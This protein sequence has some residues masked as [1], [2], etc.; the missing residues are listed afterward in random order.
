M[1]KLIDFFQDHEKDLKDINPIYLTLSLERT[2]R[3][4]I[5]CKSLK[6]SEKSVADSI[7]N[8][9]KIFKNLNK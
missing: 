7:N 2:L 4:I 1:K 3:A 8:V 9:Y 5:S 6:V